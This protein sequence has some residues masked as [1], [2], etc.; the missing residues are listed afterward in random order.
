MGFVGSATAVALPV[1][2]EERSFFYKFVWM[3]DG[4]RCELVH[5]NGRYQGW[6]GRA[7]WRNEPGEQDLWG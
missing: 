3:D 5:I 4:A 6:M 1:W 2:A 7:S